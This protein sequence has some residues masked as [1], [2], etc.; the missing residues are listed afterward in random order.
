M[1]S[2]FFKIN[3][4]FFWQS[5]VYYGNFST[6]VQWSVSS[7]INTW[8]CPTEA[9]IE[10]KLRAT[11]LTQCQFGAQ[12]SLHTPFEGHIFLF[13]PQNWYEQTTRESSLATCKQRPWGFRL[14]P[15]RHL[16]DDFILSCFA[17]SKNRAL[18]AKTS[19]SREPRWWRYS[20]LDSR[21][22]ENVT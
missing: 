1:A 21:Q 13:W 15:A 11:P 5:T 8:C 22:I 9:A 2:I 12:I 16:Y 6:A 18:K 20:S 7:Q 4:R 3:A 17:L 10:K 19:D 14:R